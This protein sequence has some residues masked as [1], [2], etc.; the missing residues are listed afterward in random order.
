MFYIDTWIWAA[1]CYLCGWIGLFSMLSYLIMQALQWISL[2]VPQNLRRKYHAEWALVTGGSS[3]IGK[4]I[5]EKL[6]RQ[7]INVVLV[8]LGDAMLAKTFE[9]L[10][11]RHP[12]V[13]F[14]KVGID[15]GDER[16]VTYMQPIIAATEDI[17]VNLLFN[18]AGYIAPGFFA[19]G[20]LKSLRSNFECNAGCSIAITHHFL[21]KML[22]RKSRGLISFTSSAAC[23]LPGPTATLYS[24]TKAFLTSFASTLAAENY[25]AGIDVVVIHPS[26]VDTNFYKTEGPLLGSLQAAQKAAALP[27]DTA[28]HIFA[29][30]GRMTVR[31]Q[32]LTCASFR[33][34]NKII[35]IQL[36][37]ELITRFAWISGDHKKL[38]RLSKI[39]NYGNEI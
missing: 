14:R 3:G 21:R 7:G 36:L 15:L 23:Y 26:P 6:A 28:N 8:A 33:L 22:A 25:D 27:I 16:Y 38:V 35:D 29:S 34:L 9:E 30:A 1:F 31:D 10:S 32:G 20:D 2:K 24:P 37:V 13:K 17:Y 11:K 5:A 19:D 4:A 18:N 12:S 39:R